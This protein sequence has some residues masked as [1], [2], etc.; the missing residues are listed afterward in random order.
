[1]DN[2]HYYAAIDLGTNS[3]RLVIA[4]DQGKYLCTRNV[5][6]ALG[7]GMYKEM[8]FTP[9][10]FARGVNCL[11]AFKD[12]I[13]RY[14][15]C[16]L[17][18]VATAGCRMAKNAGDFLTSVKEKSGIELEVIDGVEE[19]RLN[20]KGAASHARGKAP[21]VLLYDIGG[22]STEITLAENNDGQRII[23]TI[24]IPWGARNASEAFVINDY[25]EQQALALRREIEKYISI[26][27]DGAGWKKYKNAC[28]CIATSSS[29]LRLAAM[30]KGTGKYDRQEMDGVKMSAE[31]MNRQIAM[32]YGTTEK[33]RAASPY[34]GSKRATIFI[35][36]CVIFQIIY[37]K[38]EL[39]EVTASLKSAK[40][41]IIEEL[42]KEKWPN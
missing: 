14:T 19:A 28:C 13:R 35:A 39:K 18:A 5:K 7:E 31:D 12:E 1:M 37:Q 11:C 21:Y 15:P 23:Y 42:R 24:S 16:R 41:G 30:I 33:E 36:A 32:V 17:R 29:P 26:F 4:D 22:G 8:K 9:E 20:L 27:I 10:A 34:I 6:T 40:D 38:L 2:R 25:D 3:C